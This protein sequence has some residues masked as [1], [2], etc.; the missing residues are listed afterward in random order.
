MEKLIEHTYG[1][2]AYMKILMDDNQE[3]EITVYFRGNGQTYKTTA[4]NNPARREEIIIAFNAL[5]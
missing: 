4:D 5:Y 1:L 2:S 3:E